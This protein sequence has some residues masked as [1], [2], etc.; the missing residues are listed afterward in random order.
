M[1]H[2]K[3]DRTWLDR[4]LMTTALRVIRYHYFRLELWGPLAPLF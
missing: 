2:H 4:G 3:V 1:D